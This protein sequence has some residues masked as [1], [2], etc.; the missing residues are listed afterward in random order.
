MQ[1]NQTDPG[2]AYR[3]KHHADQLATRHRKSL[4]LAHHGSRIYPLQRGSDVAICKPTR[5]IGR[6][7]A[8]NDL[9]RPR[10]LQAELRDR[11][12]T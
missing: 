6:V 10:R 9:P 5:P 3:R 7:N 8:G 12:A 1:T 11:R 2:P 4:N